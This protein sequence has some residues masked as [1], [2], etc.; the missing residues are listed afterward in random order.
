MIVTLSQGSLVI[1]L[2][3]G[4]GAKGDMKINNKQANLDLDQCMEKAHVLDI[5]SPNLSFSQ[6]NSVGRQMVNA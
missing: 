3:R 6:V 4:A 5:G 1:G 2:S